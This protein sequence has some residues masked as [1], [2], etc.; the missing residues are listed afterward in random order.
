MQLPPGKH[1]EF[2]VGAIIDQASDIQTDHL[3]TFF[4]F[5]VTTGRAYV[6]PVTKDSYEREAAREVPPGFDS[7]FLQ[8]VDGERTPGQ[9]QHTYG[10]HNSDQV[11]LL[12]MVKTKISVNPLNQNA[13]GDVKDCTVCGERADVYCINDGQYFCGEHYD[14]AHTRPGMEFLREHKPVPVE[15]K[16]KDF[17]FCAEHHKMYEFYS[18]ESSKAF[19][20][21]CIVAH[22]KR[23]ESQD[24][25]IPIEEAFRIAYDECR[26]EDVALNEKKKVIENQLALVKKKMT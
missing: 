24:S 1:V 6:R 5:K 25:T 13:Q 9:F 23:A 18:N 12:Y 2:K 21:Q 20:S 16:P 19:C 3:Y 4:L 11:R 8:D 14:E 7:V 15:S 10:I 26:T 22:V 17:G